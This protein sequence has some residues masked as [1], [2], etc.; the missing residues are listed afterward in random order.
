MH[1]EMRDT[2]LLILCSPPRPLKMKSRYERA[3]DDRYILSSSVAAQF[4]GGRAAE[5]ELA[6]GRGCTSLF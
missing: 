6:G 2:P 3:F 1:D 4:L 5:S